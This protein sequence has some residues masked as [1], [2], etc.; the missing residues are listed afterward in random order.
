MAET[1]LYYCTVYCAVLHLVGKGTVLCCLCFRCAARMK[2]G[3]GFTV[4]TAQQRK[5]CTVLYCAVHTK[6]TNTQARVEGKSVVL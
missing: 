2:G 3:C 4:R 6:V 5:Y 1:N